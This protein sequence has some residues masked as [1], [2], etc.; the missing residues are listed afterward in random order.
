MGVYDMISVLGHKDDGKI[1]GRKNEIRLSLA[2]IFRDIMSEIAE[3]VY[4]AKGKKSEDLRDYFKM[5]YNN[6]LRDYEKFGFS[7]SYLFD[8]YA[9]DLPFYFSGLDDSFVPAKYIVI[10]YHDEFGSRGAS[11]SREKSIKGVEEYLTNWSVFM[12]KEIKDDK[13][14]LIILRNGKLVDFDLKRSEKYNDKLGKNYTKY[15]ISNIRDKEVNKTLQ[16]YF[17]E[18]YILYEPKQK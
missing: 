15:S 11:F 12:N 16:S 17:D 10:T 8:K 7:G 1:K 5:V 3:R 2:D 6:L 14:G 4:T 9:E 13:D 18:F